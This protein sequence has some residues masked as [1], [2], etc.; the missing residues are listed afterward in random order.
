MPKPRNW[1]EIEQNRWNFYIDAFDDINEQLDNLA[2]EVYRLTD[3]TRMTL[4]DIM[5]EK[6]H[7][8]SHAYKRSELDETAK[9]MS[10]KPLFKAIQRARK[11]GSISKSSPYKPLVTETNIASYTRRKKGG[12][13]K[14]LAVKEHSRSL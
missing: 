1:A 6:S 12:K 4:H 8:Y 10:N 11:H 14:C 7:P 2:Y 13:R 9:I 3:K 5:Q